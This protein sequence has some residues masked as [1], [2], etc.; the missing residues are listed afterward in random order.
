[1]RDPGRFLVLWMG[2]LFL[3]PLVSHAQSGAVSVRVDV[4]ESDLLAKPPTAN[5]TSYNGDYTG[6]RYSGLSQITPHNVSGLQAQW[7][8][9]SRNSQVLEVTPVVINGIMYV[10]SGNDAFALDARTG[11]V[12]WSHSRSL[13]EGLIEDAAAH[14]N[15]GVA[16]WHSRVY[17][18]TD[19]AH[20]LCLDARSGSLIWDVA[21]GDIKGNP[22]NGA[23]SVPLIVHGKVIVAPA[24]GDAGVRGKIEA[25]DAETGKLVWRFW[26]IPGPGE[27]NF[28]T[29][30]KGDTWQHGGVTAWMPGSYDAETNTLFWGTGNPSP[31]FEGSARPGDNLYGDCV[32]ALDPDSGRLKWY[33]QFTPHDLY[34]YDAV[35]TPVLIDGDYKGQPR[36]LLVEANRNGFIYVLDRTNGKFLGA[37]LFD[38]SVN[39]ARGIDANGRPITTGVI[40]T[41]QGTKIC[42]GI[43]GATNWFSPSYNPETHLF[44]FM[45]LQECNITRAK[46][47][48]F[49]KG[50]SYY[51]TGVERIEEEP[52][53]KILVAFDV[54]KGEIAWRYPQVGEGNSWAGTLSTA[55]GLVFFGDDAGS[56]E[57]IDARDGKPLWHFNTGQNI[58]ASPMAYSVDGV[59]YVAI[60]AG[61]DIFSFA[62]PH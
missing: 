2:I 57:A 38:P 29:W 24:G 55:G 25:Y 40:P 6:R 23:T 37:T 1:M 5:W 36:K 13:T 51:N 43:E 32:L 56:F 35:E 30:G 52:G 15:R 11:R 27:P 42:P 46:P 18:E 50:K 58:H 39:W 17:M 12:L 44:Y 7:V 14:H 3:R 45:A 22:A 47:Q 49:V 21:F 60:A 9:H 8:F 34:D 26:T 53:K 19:D 31:D 16:V 10:T 28:G 20:L 62:L 4:K 59:Q 33:F 54:D 48:P 41:P 61:S